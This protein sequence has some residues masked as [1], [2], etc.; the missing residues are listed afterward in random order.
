MTTA[1]LLLV[2]VAVVLLGM[3]AAAA[4][5]KNDGYGRPG[6]ST[7]RSHV[8]DVFDPRSPTRFA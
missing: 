6:R 2:L 7:P 4:F 5:V 8:P 3:L 1:L